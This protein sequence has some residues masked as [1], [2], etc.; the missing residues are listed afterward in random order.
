M[1]SV[2]AIALAA[3]GGFGGGVDASAGKTGS[4]TI[5]SFLAEQPPGTVVD[6]G[7]VFASFSANSSRCTRDVQ[8]EC[9]VLECPTG[10]AP[11]A[12]A[13]TLA[14]KGAA[15]PVSLPP[16][17]DNSYTDVMSDSPL[18]AGGETLEFSATGGDVP[19]FSEAITAPA[20]AQITS[21]AKP[22][23]FLAVDRTTGFR[24]TWSGG[25]AGSV[26]VALF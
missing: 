8:N 12:S 19:A 21:P 16:N 25:G 5:Q 9:V 26:Q 23:Q 24:V 10:A 13:G 14:I 20:K 3:C 17:G 2:V 4:I 6:G 15:M 18:Y 7:A 22:A 11:L 1:R